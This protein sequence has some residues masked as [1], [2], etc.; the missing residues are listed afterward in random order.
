MYSFLKILTRVILYLINGAPQFKNKQRIPKG[1]YILVAPHRTWFDPLYFALGA[2]PK[3]FAF[4]A[5]K[6]L[7]KNHILRF[8]LKHAN[9]ISVD[10]NHPGP[11]VIKQ[12]V[13][14]LKQT[15]KS[16][17]MFP[18]GTRHS[19]EL[20][21]GATLIAKLSKTPLLPA[22]YQGPLTFKKLFSRK[23]TIINFGEPIYLDAKIK[24]DDNGQKQ[25]EKQMQKAFDK[26]DKEV[27]PNFKYVDPASKKR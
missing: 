3:E 9:V 17:I 1:N 23:K 19:Q 8:I 20:K 14:V 12:P 25:I 16:L 7:F 24:L 11:S 15:N 18:S 10:R 27:N 5:K 26:L 2:S 13:K 4:I 6:E 21:G 22:V